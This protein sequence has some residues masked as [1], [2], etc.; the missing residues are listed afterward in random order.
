MCLFL[1]LQ[2][3]CRRHRSDAEVEH[4]FTSH[5]SGFEQLL[6]L[7]EVDP[8]VTMRSNLLIVQLELDRIETFTI[9]KDSELPKEMPKQ[10]W[11]Q[12]QH[13]LSS[14]H[15]RTLYKGERGVMFQIDEPGIL[16][17]DSQK[18][19]IY[20]SAALSSRPSLDDLAAADLRNSLCQATKNIQGHWYVYLSYS[21]N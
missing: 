10:R 15:V 2:V 3:A 6:A 19:I 5:R 17:G 12:Y 7:A 20:S 1:L 13:L 11:H 14:L 16:N 8:V 18:G 4:W 9:R 21:C